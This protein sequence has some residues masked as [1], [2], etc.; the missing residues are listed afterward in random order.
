MKSS[1][2]GGGAILADAGLKK[3]I[4]ARSRSADCCFHKIS[5]LETMWVRKHDY[6]LEP[7]INSEQ[8]CL[9]LQTISGL[10]VT[11]KLQRFKKLL[12]NVL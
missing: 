9:L 8:A 1:T 12:I 3:V 10:M 6:R 2:T 7:A 4:I 11:H 5:W